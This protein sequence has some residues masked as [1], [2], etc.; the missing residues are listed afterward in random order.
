MHRA[1]VVIESERSDVIYN[2]IKQETAP[3]ANVSIDFDGKSLKL[4]ISS[5][6]ATNLRAALNSFLKWAD[7][8]DKIGDV[9]EN[10]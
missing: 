2:A 1:S 4:E 7:L 10:K 3:R 5:E 9:V 8:V 6:N